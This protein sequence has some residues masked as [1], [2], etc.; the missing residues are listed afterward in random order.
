MQTWRKL[1]RL[2]HAGLGN[3]ARAAWS[4]AQRR[5]DGAAAAA[6]DLRAAD[7]ATACF[8]QP[9]Q[10]FAVENPA[11]HFLDDALA[12]AGL[13]GETFPDNVA[14]TLAHADAA[15][16]GAFSF[17]G[18]DVVF[19]SGIDWQWCPESGGSW[20]FLDSGAYTGLN[21]YY[22]E[23]RPGDIKYPWELNRHQYFVAL[24]KAY[25]YTGN[26]QYVETVIA[27]MTDWLRAN[28][29]GRGVNWVSAM[30]LGIRLISWVNAFW[31]L[32]RSPVFAAYG[33]EPCV[34][35]MYLH[36]RRLSRRLTTDWLVRTN[37]LIAETAA[38][39]A[40]ATLFPMFPDC[41]RWRSRALRL[42]C[43][44]VRE[45]IF[46]D[47]VNR[48]QATGYHRFVVDF[49]LL[50]TRLC[51]LNGMGVPKILDRRLES[52]LEYE[53][54]LIPPDNRAPQIGDCDDGR[55]MLFSE[56]DDFYDFR[57]WLAVGAARFRR[58]EFAEAA[59][60]G[61][62]EAAWVLGIDGWRRFEETGRRGAQRR[63]RM[64]AAGGAA[65]L[66]GEGPA[67]GIMAVMRC[68]PFGHGGPGACSHSHADM[69][70]PIIWWGSKPLAVDSG[71][72]GYLCETEV[73]DAFRGSAAHNTFAPRGLDQGRMMPLKD[74]SE[75]P[76]TRVLRWQT[77]RDQVLVAAE[78]RAATG[79][80]H[81]RTLRLE[82]RDAHL[83]IE[84]ELR[85]PAGA[86]V[87][88]DWL[89]HLSPG[90]DATVSEPNA[91]T[92]RGAEGPVAV[93][94]HEGFD[95]AEVI[96]AWYSP[97][98][99]VKENNRCIRLSTSGPVAK[100]RV[101]IENPAVE[102]VAPGDAANA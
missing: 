66:R 51:E 92:V 95:N 24:A 65:M 37:H 54:T 84:D 61:A 73:R 67:A 81:V 53:A 91:V 86:T 10:A 62:E 22:R 42:F 9:A 41:G 25:L 71:T 69:L 18:R 96:D 20:P 17:L 78:C 83:V 76:D 12:T 55:G 45:Q 50:V 80:R 15:G 28:P 2:R 35:G 36:A 98:Y 29:C 88:L 4:R 23:G 60:H 30:E 46:A 79:F 63:S 21:S 13:V 6:A 89:L 52:M 40:F 74:W 56:R 39:F 77:G 82:Q 8:A 94:R 100:T 90:L 38:L 72:C 1:Q 7:A 87:P 97:R 11:H 3:A 16:R 85:L 59:G 93:L 70:A 47:G 5:V 68:G 14:A 33:V 43:H 49:L 34:R 32:R 102:A 31:L 64:F 19:E 48:E 99:G 27:H 57:G 44:E 26:E 75:I 58:P 101:T